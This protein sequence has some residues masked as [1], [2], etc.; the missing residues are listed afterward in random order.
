MNSNLENM[1]PELNLLFSRPVT[2]S[3]DNRK[4]MTSEAVHK[5]RGKKKSK[6]IPILI[7]PFS[8]FGHFIL[9]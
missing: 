5:A 9:S 8:P 2:E 6:V 3:Q 1:I 7:L 4:G